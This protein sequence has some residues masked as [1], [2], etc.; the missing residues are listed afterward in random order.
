M[1]GQPRELGSVLL[2]YSSERIRARL[3]EYPT[4]LQVRRPKRRSMSLG[5]W[6]AVLMCLS[7]SS[8]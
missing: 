5:S 3:S 2:V 6:T 4:A 7:F 8:V 1:D